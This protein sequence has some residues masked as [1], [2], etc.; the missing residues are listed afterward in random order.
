MS[1]PVVLNGIV[2]VVGALLGVPFAGGSI[3]SI[4]NMT[5]PWRGMLVVA[6]L[7]VP[8]M[9]VISALGTALA[10]GRTAPPIVVGF[11]ALPWLYG[12]GFVLLMLVSFD[13]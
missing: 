6:A 12:L 4:A 8:A 13:G 11:I 1:W 7:L 5:V 9:F 10:Y 3:I 2:C